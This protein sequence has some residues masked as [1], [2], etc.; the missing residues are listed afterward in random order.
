MS[1]LL[2][3]ILKFVC[4]DYVNIGIFGIKILINI[5]NQCEKYAFQNIFKLIY[6]YENVLE[7]WT[8]PLFD[9]NQVL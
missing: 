1:H 5:Q 7:L 2:S 6:I 8:A 9:F 4:L 3:L